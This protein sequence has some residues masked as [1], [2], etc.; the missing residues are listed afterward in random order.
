MLQKDY[1]ER[2]IE[3]FAKMVAFI[4][5]RTKAGAHEDANAALER[6][7]ENYVG[8]SLQVLDSLSYEA[9]CSLLR[10]GGSLD[11][12][13]CL[14]LADLRAL[15]GRLREAA[16]RPELAFR[17]YVTALRLYT[18]AAEEVDFSAFEGHLELAETAAKYLRLRELEPGADSVLERY[19]AATGAIS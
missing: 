14:V 9:L 17:S 10:V 4:L 15:D 18:E 1:L 7:A 19:L 3:S 8:L 11:S 6:A 2:A 16:G 5:D 13:R 12:E